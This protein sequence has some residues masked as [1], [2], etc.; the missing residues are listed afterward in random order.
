MSVLRALGKQSSHSDDLLTAP[1]L[2]ATVYKDLK[3][4][5]HYYMCDR[6]VLGLQPHLRRGEFSHVTMLC[7]SAMVNNCAL[8]IPPLFREISAT[9]QP[10]CPFLKTKH[11]K[12]AFKCLLLEI[13][14]SVPEESQTSWADVMSLNARLTNSS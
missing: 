6:S 11:F 3:K 10:T 5:K 14:L 8:R 7:G 4:C 9:H 13:A 12:E 1:H 2:A